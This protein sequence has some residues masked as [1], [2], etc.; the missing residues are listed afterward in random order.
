MHFGDFLLD[1]ISSKEILSRFLYLILIG[2]SVYFLVNA[3][4]IRIKSIRQSIFYIGI[5]ISVIFSAV[6]LVLVFFTSSHAHIEK[7]ENLANIGI[8]FIPVFLC[9]HISSQVSYRNMK[10]L[11]V[12]FLYIIPCVLSLIILRDLYFTNLFSIIPHMD[13]FIWYKIIFFIYTGISLIRAFL[14]CFNVFF[15]MSPRMRVSTWLMLISIT[16]ILLLTVLNQILSNEKITI[17]SDNQTIEVLLPSAAAV[18]LIAIVYP[19]HFA[20]RITPSEDVIVT[21]REFVVEGLTT[22][23]LVLNRRDEI[24]DW[25]KKN[26][27]ENDPIPSP[28]YREPFSVYKQR[29]MQDQNRFTLFNEDT[30]IVSRDGHEY[31]Y[32][33]HKQEVRNRRMLFGYIIEI[34]EI[35]PIYSLIRNF[36]DVAYIDQLTM[37]HNRNSYLNQ[38]SNVV[39]N[40][41]MP[42]VI[43]VG[44][45]NRLKYINDVYGHLQ[46]D[47]LLITVADIIKKAMP[48]DAYAAR[49]GGDEFILLI[50]NSSIIVAERF[51]AETERLCQETYNEIFGN[52]SISWGYDIMVSENQSYNDVFTNADQMMYTNKR[53]QYAFHSSGLVPEGEQGSR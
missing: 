9:R 47:E 40:E 39:K 41:F 17:F 53:T 48:S 27:N 42:L 12:I 7:L 28:L 5:C 35:T 13:G 44:D 38:V 29:I 51:I 46:G 50:P 16:S 52:P 15:Q 24:L 1:L 31:F 19:L 8:I 14:Y 20:L 3:I 32:L 49:I 33:L 25:N 26:R 18:A 43:L 23:I 21:S 22:S 37:L 10:T 30:I 4:Y 45:V 2:I 36:E 11:F 34:S 6:C